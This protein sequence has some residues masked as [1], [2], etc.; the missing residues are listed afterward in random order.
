[1]PFWKIYDATLA[2][3]F[4]NHPMR[5]SVAGTYED[6][7]GI[8]KEML[9]DCY[10]TFYNPANMFLV[11]TGN[12]DKDEIMRVIKENQSKKHFGEYQSVKYGEYNEPDKVVKTREVVKCNTN[13]A[14]IAYSIK[15]PINCFN[16]DKRKLSVYMFIIF[17][18]I[19]GDTSKFDY[20]A[21]KKEIITNTLYYN[22]LNIGSHFIVS[23]I[24]TGDKYE[25]L[26]K[27]ID[28][29]LKNIKFDE[30]ELERKKKVLISNEVFS[31]E[32][33]E[34]INDMIVDNIIFDNKIETNMISLI[35][36]INMVELE[37]IVSKIDF[38]NKSIVILRK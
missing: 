5:H 12:Y 26:I 17:N 6:I 2:N 18:L 10:N 31:Y 13:V 25:E 27:M 8:T 37:E 9:Y 23:L 36:D 3:I 4:V 1:M 7:R 32:N 11:V 20:E 16:I 24:N 30:K 35:E 22:V 33:V 34:L 15:I 21:K 14:K 19:F 28:E 29:E 38:N